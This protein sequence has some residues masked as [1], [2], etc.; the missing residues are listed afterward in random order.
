MRPD[1]ALAGRPT[2]AS[3]AWEPRHWLGLERERGSTPAIR[4]T[5]RVIASCAG[6]AT[7]GERFRALPL[8]PHHARGARVC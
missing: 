5:G 6:M 1:V 4:L 7:G 3:R 2:Q 8:L